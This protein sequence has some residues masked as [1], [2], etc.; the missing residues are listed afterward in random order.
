MDGLPV[1]LSR[2]DAGR[3]TR[4]F[5][6]AVGGYFHLYG[7]ADIFFFAEP[8]P[9][10]LVELCN[11]TQLEQHAADIAAALQ[12]V[13]SRQTVGGRTEHLQGRRLGLTVDVVNKKLQ[14]M[15]RTCATWLLFRV[16]SLAQTATLKG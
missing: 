12:V 13:V 8:L 7:S 1:W 9:Q 15:Q 6:G 14:R 5:E 16:T 10:W 3:N 2:T 11:I 4:T